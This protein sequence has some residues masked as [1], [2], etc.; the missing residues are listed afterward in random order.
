MRHQAPF[1][2]VGI[3]VA[4]K[5]KNITRKSIALQSSHQTWCKHNII[6]PY[7]YMKIVDFNIISHLK[8]SSYIIVEQFR[9]F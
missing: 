6:L 8:I 5:K 1:Y 9:M 7:L 4:K 3:F 2:R